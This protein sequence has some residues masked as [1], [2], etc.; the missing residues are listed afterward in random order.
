MLKDYG[1]RHPDW[2]GAEKPPYET[3]DAAFDMKLSDA[4]EWLRINQQ[5]RGESECRHKYTRAD[6]TKIIRG[7]KA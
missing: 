2:I 5:W 1:S 3:H 7:D 4:I 6:G